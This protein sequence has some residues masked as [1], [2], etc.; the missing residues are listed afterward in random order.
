MLLSETF[1]TNTPQTRRSPKCSPMP[2]LGIFGNPPVNYLSPSASGT[3]GQS[4]EEQEVRGGRKICLDKNTAFYGLKY[5]VQP[6]VKRCG[7]KI[8]TEICWRTFGLVKS[9]YA[10][11]EVEHIQIYVGFS[12]LPCRKS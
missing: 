7:G 9:T 3:S 5:V 4:A 8:L 11:A 2:S 10:T 12:Q 1:I 6:C